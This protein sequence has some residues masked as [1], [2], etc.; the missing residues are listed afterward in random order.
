MTKKIFLKRLLIFLIPIIVFSVIIELIIRK[1]PNDYTFKR[2]NLIEQREQIKTLALGGSHTYYGL[3]PDLFD[4]TMFNLAYVSQTLLFDDLLL[5]K[6][7]DTLPNLKT[8]IIPIAYVSLSQKYGEGEEKWRRYNYF[9]FHDIQPPFGKW[10]EKYYLELTN[11]PSKLNIIKL[12]KYLTGE[13]MITC[14]EKGWCITF[15][16]EKVADIESSSYKAAKRHENGSLDFTE[17]LQYLNNMIAICKSKNITVYL[18]TFPFWKTYRDNLNP[19]AG[20]CKAKIL[21]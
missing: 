12:F 20:L 4:S 5:N 18:V 21:M 16:E 8:V 6:Y 1:I 2:Q 17:N 9:R 19:P 3:N 11:L 7:I 14:N 15:A 13:S 10:Y